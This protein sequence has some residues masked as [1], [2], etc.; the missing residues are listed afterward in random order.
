M[1]I[2]RNPRSLRQ[3]AIAQWARSAF[4]EQEATNLAQR[5]LRLAEEAIKAAQA[6]GVDKDMLLRLVEHVYARP[7][8]QL[9]QELGGVGICLLALAHA[10]GLDA[11]SCEQD[12]SRRVLSL[13]IDHF[14]ARN[15]AK[16]AAGFRA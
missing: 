6:A 14:R 11:D 8:G 7:K 9:R 4:G 5:G 1:D 2:L 12:E 15:E 16:N 13:S 10:A 3:R